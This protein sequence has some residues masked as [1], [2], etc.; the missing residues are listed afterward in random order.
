MLSD[1]T[2]EDTEISLLLSP[3]VVLLE[4][5]RKALLFIIRKLLGIRIFPENTVSF[6]QLLAQLRQDDANLGACIVRCW[7]HVCISFKSWVWTLMPSSPA[8]FMA[9]MLVIVITFFPNVPSLTFSASYEEQ[10]SYCL[11]GSETMLSHTIGKYP[12]YM[13]VLSNFAV[14]W[15]CVWGLFHFVSEA[16]LISGLPFSTKAKEKIK[17]WPFILRLPFAYPYHFVRKK[18]IFR[19]SAEKPWIQ[20]ALGLVS[21]LFVGLA[22]VSAPSVIAIARDAFAFGRLNPILFPESFWH[23]TFAQTMADITCF[24]L[25]GALNFK[26]LDTL[27]KRKVPLFNM[28]RAELLKK[29]RTLIKKIEDERGCTETLETHDAVLRAP[30]QFVRLR[31]VPWLVLA[32]CLGANNWY[33]RASGESTFR[34]L[35]SF[36]TDATDFNRFGQW[37]SFVLKSIFLGNLVQAF[38]LFCLANTVLRCHPTII[39]YRNM[40]QHCQKKMASIT[41]PTWVWLCNLV[42]ANFLIM[43][44]SLLGAS[45][46]IM[47]YEYGYHGVVKDDPHFCKATYYALLL[48]A[49]AVFR[50]NFYFAYKLQKA[51]AFA[52]T[53]RKIANVIE[54]NE[55][56]EEILAVLYYL[57]RWIQ[58]APSAKL[59][60]LLLHAELKHAE[61]K[62][63]EDAEIPGAQVKK[64]QI[65]R[66]NSFPELFGRDSTGPRYS[67]LFVPCEPVL[68]W[69]QGSEVKYSPQTTLAS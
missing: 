33:S 61:L 49:I 62:K 55:S 59:K 11:T 9:S 19:L 2:A 29:I 28:L 32:A 30:N 64:Y 22:Y 16:V 21:I 43:L 60:A 36:F 37:V 4:E 63:G 56:Y 8:S 34:A 51:V 47:L 65:C 23:S 18:L 13:S 42:V 68:G 26:G 67:I 1:L 7:E 35:E 50:V 25:T 45:K 46:N 66:A 10:L 20:V 40:K 41:P 24:I 14:G 15:Y 31:Y 53:L 12:S 6:F 44:P 52:I 48:T 27:F 38:V 58:T 17:S 69:V 3:E 39:A 57:D 54:K 5:D